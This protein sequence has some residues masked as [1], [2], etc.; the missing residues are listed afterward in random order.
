MSTKTVTNQHL[1]LHRQL[2][3]LPSK[4]QLNT[5]IDQTDAKL[6]VR[7]VPADQLY[8]AILDVGLVDATEI[9]QLASPEQFRT[10]VDL[11]AWKRDRIDPH[12]ILTWLRAARGDEPEDFLGKLGKIDMELLEYLL[13][14]FTVIHDKEENPDANP[15]GDTLETPEG[16]YLVEFTVDGAELAAM[17]QLVNDLIAQD[18]F[19]A[20]RLIEA[21]RWEITS[22]LEETAY[23]FR[24]ARMEDLGFPRLEQ[25]LQLFTYVDPGQAPVT[26][27]EGLVKGTERVDFLDAALSGLVPAEQDGFAE[28]LRYLVNSTLVA[29]A[30][31]PGELAATRRIAE[32]TRD[33]LNLGLQHLTGADPTRASDLVRDEPLK[34]IF[35]IGFSLT[36]QLKFKVDRLAKEPF[37][38][39]GETWL[40][41]RDEAA[42]LTSLRRKRPL[43]ALKVE[44]A[45][46]MP[47]RDRREL[48]ESSKIIE[49][50][51][52]QV[53][54]LGALLGGS[55]AEAEKRLAAFTLE[56]L[57]PQRLFTAV[58]ANALIEG[59]PRVGPLAAGNL[60]PLMKE[61]V[62]PGPQLRASAVDRALQTLEGG[63][64]DL[65]H[66]E[67][68]HM[69]DR[70]FRE[71]VAG[72]GPAFATSGTVDAAMAS[73]ILPM[74][75]L[76]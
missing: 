57:S 8:N 16:K 14:S 55:K 22:E 20:G 45:E 71:L 31:E 37:S 51:T 69:V 59:N 10:F 4:Q 50:A 32:M 43:R 15:E 40:T 72:L 19:Q 3:R 34:K 35:Q 18:P 48:D 9:V 75:D 1:D 30:A 44:G 52:R 53:A 42:A 7:S 58:A 56:A 64:D 60:V 66:A 24:A 49:Q 76:S 33:Y 26:K 27:Q 61:L 47:F 29:E 63:S 39:L 62:E 54:I 28:E 6:A 67:L 2:A 73:T 41:L 25:A 65:H 17:R 74:N 36:L 38:R 23:Q 46:P 21:I 68:R 70:V 11:A 13:R 5:L 12:Q